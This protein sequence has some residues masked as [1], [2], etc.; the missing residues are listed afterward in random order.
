M[1]DR[2]TQ[3]IDTCPVWRIH[4]K[5]PPSALAAETD[6]PRWPYRRR[7]ASAPAWKQTNVKLLRPCLKPYCLS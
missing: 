7:S 5:H 6:R 2:R 4:I 3:R 1:I